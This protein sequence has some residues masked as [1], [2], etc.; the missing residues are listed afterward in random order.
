MPMHMIQLIEMRKNENGENVK[1]NFKRG[2]EFL[3]LRFYLIVSNSLVCQGIK[4]FDNS[5]R[6]W[7]RMLISTYCVTKKIQTTT[8]YSFRLRYLLLVY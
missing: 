4:I 8:S 2:K 3:F 1:I 6:F 5:T 7:A